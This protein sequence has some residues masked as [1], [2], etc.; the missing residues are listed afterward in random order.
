MNEHDLSFLR[1]NY[2]IQRKRL[3]YDTYATKMDISSSCYAIFG[4]IGLK[5]CK[6][7]D[8]KWLEKTVKPWKELDW[9]Q[10]VEQFNNTEWEEI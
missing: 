5:I 4:T 6:Y 1:M 7:K 3:Q 9:N 8:G 2:E 10:F